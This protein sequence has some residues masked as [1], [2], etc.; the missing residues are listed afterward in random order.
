MICDLCKREFE[1]SQGRQTCSACG[2]VKGCQGVRCPYCYYE[3]VPQPKWMKKLFS[4]LRTEKGTGPGSPMTQG[5]VPFSGEATC[6]PLS[7]LP[8]NQKAEVTHLEM[9]DPQ[10]LKKLIAIGVLPGSQITLLQR[11]P[12]YVFQIGWS[13]FS[14]DRELASSIY[15]KSGPHDPAG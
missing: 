4:F 11:F 9:Q 13:Q 7:S 1:E 15:V 14:V 12:S 8:V 2:F 3:M 10:R 6:L 5:P